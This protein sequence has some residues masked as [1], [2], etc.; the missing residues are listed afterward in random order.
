MPL[1]E[2]GGFLYFKR[3]NFNMTLIGLC[4]ISK[5]IMRSFN[6]G[7]HPKYEKDGTKG[8][9]I[10]VMPS[11]DF[12][13][14][15][16]SQHIGAPCKPTVAVGDR[17]L[18]GQKVGDTEAFVS[19][20][21]HSPV[22]G[23]VVEIAPKP[24]PFGAGVL[25]VVVKSD[26]KDG[27]HPSAKAR[28]NSEKL[29]REEIVGVIREAG[30]VGMGGAMFPTHVKIAPPA[31]KKVDVLVVNGAECEPYLTCDHRLL[32]EKPEKILSGMSYVMKALGVDKAVVGIEENKRDGIERLRSENDNSNIE[33]V[34]LPIKYPQGAEKVLVKVLT[35]R[36]IPAGKLPLDSGV[37]VEN[38]GTLAAIHDAVAEGKPLIERV[39]TCAGSGVAEPKN[40]SVKV[41]TRLLDIISFCGGYKGAPGKLFVGGP[42]MGIAQPT[43]EAAT[44]KGNN[45]L[46]AFAEGTFEDPEEGPCIHCGRCTDSCPYTL[47]P[48]H[49]ANLTDAGKFEDAEAWGILDCME[50]GCCS[51]VCPAKRF[52]VQRLKYGKMKVLESKRKK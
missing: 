16:M 42:M 28:K 34:S 46:I 27:I 51:F 29:S 6:G 43:E 23:E 15:F 21:V 22:S 18:A 44:I 26:G 50:C 39:L 12:A 36:E 37:V 20:P 49:L 4:T 38:V 47:T 7:V 19:A 31:D 2:A 8:K 9:P 11:P 45:G 30:I 35:G 10:E 41:G 52:L 14:V 25:A 1:I 3:N 24:H 13:C 40:V 32:L 17:V 48:Y 33:I 5:V